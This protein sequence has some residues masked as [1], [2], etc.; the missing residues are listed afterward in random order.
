MGDQ[1]VLLLGTEVNSVF[2]LL[3]SVVLGD[4]TAVLEVHT[5]SIYRLEDF[6]H[7]NVRNIA[8][9]HKIYKPST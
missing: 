5:V 1:N 9:N 7:R 8:N 2:G 6:Y 4:A 3:N